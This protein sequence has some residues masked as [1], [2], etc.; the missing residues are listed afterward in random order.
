MSGKDC[1]I[2]DN[3]E[4]LLL[5][6]ICVMK[7]KYVYSGSDLKIGNVPEAAVIT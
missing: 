4:Y 5:Q 7:K 2:S 6:L 3:L 1:K